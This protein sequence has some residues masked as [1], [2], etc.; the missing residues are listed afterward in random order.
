MLK[1]SSQ[2]VFGCQICTQLLNS[3]SVL[4]Y[5]I[6]VDSFCL[7]S[8]SL[9]FSALFQLA[10]CS[11]CVLNTPKQYPISAL[12]PNLCIIKVH[13]SHTL[14]LLLVQ[15][16][17]L[18][19][20]IGVNISVSFSFIFSFLFSFVSHLQI[21][22]NFDIIPGWFN[23]PSSS[24][25]ISVP[26]RPVFR[27]DISSLCH[28]A[29]AEYSL[30]LLMPISHNYYTFYTDSSLAD[31]GSSFLSMGWSWIQVHKAYAD[32]IA[33]FDN[34]QISSWPSSTY[35]EIAA[36]YSALFQVLLNASITFY[37]N[38]SVVISGLPLY[39]S[40]TFTDGH[41]YPRHLNFEL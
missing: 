31:L 26:V 15:K 32:G 34:G 30:S 35:A 6:L 40:S 28:A 16:R 23:F 21:L 2:V 38:S 5:W 4:T 17:L 13:L 9:T 27:L 3:T 19:S 12:K 14:L 39:S 1:S 11:G 7:D 20:T 10:L 37:I 36:V 41:S 29:A 22:P 18:N 8:S 25:A 24:L 33:T